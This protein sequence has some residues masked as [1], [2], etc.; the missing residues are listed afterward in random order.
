MKKILIPFCVLCFAT[1]VSVI[2][3]FVRIN[4]FKNWKPTVGTV[5]YT[6]VRSGGPHGKFG[7]SSTVYY[8]YSY[9]VDRKTYKGL[10]AFSGKKAR[11]E[12][13]EKCEIWYDPSNA[14]KSSFGGK[15]G[16]DLYIY[17]PF[18]MALPCMLALYSY[19]AKK[20]KKL[21]Y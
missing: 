15:P 10:D 14:E 17:I 19:F 2:I 9:E 7:A 8:Y 1:I 18:I 12:K 21:L 16:P 13:G 20:E 5:T 3:Y 6:E 11:Y 4:E